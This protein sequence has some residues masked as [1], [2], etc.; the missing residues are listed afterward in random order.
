MTR[1]DRNLGAQPPSP[2]RC[3]VLYGLK[4]I[5]KKHGIREYLVT[6]KRLRK[7]LFRHGAIDAYYAAGAIYYRTK[8]I[9][10]NKRIRRHELEHARQERLLGRTMFQTLYHWSQTLFG[11]QLCPFE[12]LARLKE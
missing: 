4:L 11:Y 1:D 9:S 6:D 12:T 3:C 10:R 8:K 7:L 5:R 2:F